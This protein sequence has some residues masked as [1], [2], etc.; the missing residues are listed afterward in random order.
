MRVSVPSWARVMVST[1]ARPR[2]TP[3]WS[4]CTRSVPR[5]NGSVSVA[6]NSGLSVSPVFSTVSVTVA[7]RTAVSTHTVPRA[8]RLCTIALCTRFVVS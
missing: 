3:A 2:P 1:I 4:V 6:A 5:R 7:G 8:G